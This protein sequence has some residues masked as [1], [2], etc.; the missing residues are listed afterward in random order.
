MGISQLNIESV[1][2]RLAQDKEEIRSAQRLR[3]N[4]FYEEYKAKPDEKMAR[5]RRDI[6]DYDDISD[7]LVVLDKS[8]KD[9]EE[10][11]VGTYRLLNHQAVG[12]N[13]TFYTSSEYNIDPLLNS[14]QPLLELGRSCVLSDYRTRPVLQLLWQGIVDYM[15]SHDIGLLFGCASLTGTDIDQMS[16]QL[17]YMHHYHLAPEN[18]RPVAL[19]ER[20]VD[21]NLHA[22]EDIDARRVF[23]ELPPLIKGYL[24]V[25]AT[26]GE[27]AVIDHQFNTTDVCIV[28][29][30][31]EMASR[32]RRHYSRKVQNASLVSSGSERNSERRASGEARLTA[33]V[34]ETTA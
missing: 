6:D 30:V 26:I 21:M 24:R 10:R 32:Y 4:V 5:E 13:G 31:S 3:Y 8:I 14:G 1:E 7:H 23:K 27:G 22:K 9:P 18:L 20:Y 28:F 33:S 29:P 16:E 19:E 17:A 25:G 11:I 34:N 15:L 2:I 12:D